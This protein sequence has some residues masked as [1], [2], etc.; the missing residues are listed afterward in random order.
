MTRPGPDQWQ[1]VSACEGKDQ[2]PAEL[3]KRMAKRARSRRGERISAYRCPVC[4]KWHVGGGDR[5]ATKDVRR[6]RAQFA[7]RW[8]P[9]AWCAG[10]D[11]EE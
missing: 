8:E 5:F 4:G 2:L 10:D 6:I 3:A 7:E 1:A 9:R 11:A